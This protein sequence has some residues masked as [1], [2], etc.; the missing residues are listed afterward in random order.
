MNV[1]LV[2]IDTLRADHLGCYGWKRLTSPHLDAFAAGGTVFLDMVS[3]HIPTHP[4]YTTMFSGHDAMSHQVISH[5]GNVGPATGVKMIAEILGEQGYFT[6]A[7]DNLG[8][9]FERGFQDYRRYSWVSNGTEP[10]RKA[11]AVNDVALPL[12]QD[13]ANQDKPF[14][15]FLHYWDP[16]TPYLPPP[17]F[18]RMF[19]EG[20]EKDPADRSMDEVFAFAPFEKY[21]RAW[22]P[23]VTSREFVAAQYDA[24][25]AYNDAVLAH[26]FCRLRELNLE[27]ETLVIVTSDHGETMDEHGCFF[28][29]HGLYDANVCVPLILRCPG[30]IPAGQRLRGQVAT[31][32]IAPTILD[33]L[34]LGDLIAENAMIGTSLRPLAERGSQ[35]GNYD[36]LYVAECS[37]MRKHGIRTND[38]KYI[39]ALE[40][41][42]HGLPPVE[43]YDLNEKPV[44]ETTNLVDAR[45]DVVADLK[46]VLEDWITRRPAQTGRPNPIMEQG[47]TM[48]SVG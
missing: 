11:E 36:A 7:A 43:L 26:V 22:L 31:F 37:W 28:D 17:P 15:L 14:F 27:G 32:D 33:Y 39:E 5:G 47:I 45:P 8:R 35:K 23:G 30:K 48:R 10:Q 21:F 6:G 9:W 19:F 38:W 44:K 18:S 46:G 16:H 42:F 25:I 34:G 12:L 4:G 41:D 40:P 2:A 24:E 29:H 3:P 20:D 1:L 13:A